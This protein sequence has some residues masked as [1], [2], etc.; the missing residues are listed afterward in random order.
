[1]CKSQFLKDVLSEMTTFGPGEGARGGWKSSPGALESTLERVWKGEEE[2]KKKNFSA[3]P[4]KKSWC[5]ET[6]PD[7][8][9]GPEN[10]VYRL[11]A[12]A[13]DLASALAPT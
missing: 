6:A 7:A 2:K 11:H 3:M 13:A 9:P 10:E 5:P 4:K 12:S 8:S 1:M